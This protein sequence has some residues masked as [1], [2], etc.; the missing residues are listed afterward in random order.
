MGERRL[1]LKTVCSVGAE[2]RCK[3]IGTPIMIMRKVDTACVGKGRANA[4]GAGHGRGIGGA[5]AGREEQGKAEGGGS[6]VGTVIE[7]LGMYSRKKRNLLSAISR[8]FS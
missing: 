7:F 6:P 4:L 5:G 8:E 3:P 2:D 1:H